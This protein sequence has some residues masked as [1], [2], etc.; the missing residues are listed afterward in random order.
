VRSRGRLRR[1]FASLPHSGKPRTQNQY[2]VASDRGYPSIRN[3]TQW[4]LAEP[5]DTLP[6]MRLSPNR[7]LVIVFAVVLVAFCFAPIHNYLHHGSSKDYPLWYH[8]AQTMLHGGDVYVKN[9]K[10]EFPYMYPPGAAVMLS[11]L[12]MFG[13][14]GMI[15]AMVVINSLGWIFTA[16]V[17]VKLVTGKW[18]G[19]DPL[20]YAVPSLCCVAYMWST[21]LLGGP[22]ML[23]GACLLG[24]FLCL[25]KG[26]PW[27]AGGLLAAAAA[28]KAFPILALPYLIWRRHWTA[29]ASTF[30][31]LFIFLYA[32]PAAYRGPQLAL[33]DLNVWSHGMLMNDSE[34]SIGQRA[35][36][37][38]TWQNGSIQ[39]VGS[40]LLRGDVAADTDEEF[41]NAGYD[42]LHVNIADISYKTVNHLIDAAI[43]AIGLGYVLLMVPASRRTVQTD[44]V[45]QAILLILIITFAPLSFTYNNSWLM[46][47]M[48]V[49][50]NFAL[51]G[52]VRKSDRVIAA[53][54]FAM[55]IALL[56]FSIR[57]VHSPF[58][59]YVRAMGNTFWACMILL[60]ELAWVYRVYAKNAA[61]TENT[62]A[63]EGTRLVPS[64]EE[65]V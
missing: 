35:V 51:R 1:V 22:A 2:A 56:P 54:V 7:A 23:L 64:S 11:P 40:R 5:S 12:S 8:T 26:K 13:P 46:L 32:W 4:F 62:L 17:C 43:L 27:L 21:Y 25:R 61:V 14:G 59:R 34:K 36:R 30:V 52:R 57:V 24:M 49:I 3:Q 44:T 39:S 47:P 65:S 37:S 31:W 63:G 50:L 28:F 60:V 9:D 45:E 42:D 33:R 19:E 38:F 15:A 18:L 48:V 16:L 6:S 55:A 29:V 58:M 41:R 20:L 10:G 53:I